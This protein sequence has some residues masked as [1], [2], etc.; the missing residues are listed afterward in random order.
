[1][2]KVELTNKLNQLNVKCCFN[3]QKYDFDKL[4]FIIVG[5]N[6]GKT[7]F[8]ENRFFIGP[9]GQELRKHFS[10]NDLSSDFDN[11]CIIYNK[12]FIHTPKTKDLAE[13]EILIGKELFNEPQ[14][15]C[16][17]EIADTANKLNLPILIFG[18]SYLHP[19][20][21]F[22]KFWQ[23]INTYTIN[24]K[25]ILVFNHPSPPYLQFEKEWNRY[26]GQISYKSNLDLLIQIG[27]INT[28]KINNK[29]KSMNA[30][31]FYGE[32]INHQNGKETWAK[33]FVLTEDGKFYCEYLD[34]MNPARVNE[35]FDFESFKAQD[36][37]WG[38][39]Q[40]IVEIDE[41]TA[42]TK[43]LTR[44]SNW[45]ARYLSSLN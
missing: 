23:S 20:L 41:S 2:S 25:S 34:Y 39:Y 5:D 14:D 15:L 36:Y 3:N 45:V 12:T 29:Y 37:K 17:K 43:T 9:S 1:M 21:M 18:K 42:K 13:I 8:V 6:P 38:G 7:E 4:K 27:K 40:S 26:K 35:N 28:K 31:F 10:N 44:Q 32:H 22:D 30:R 11:E 19:D 24:K 33:L 16:A